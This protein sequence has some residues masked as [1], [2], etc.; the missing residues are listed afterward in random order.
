M[1]HCSFAPNTSNSSVN[2]M[3][4][5]FSTTLALLVQPSNFSF[6]LLE[7]ERTI[8]FNSFALKRVS[9]Y[10]AAGFSGLRL[11]RP[12]ASKTHSTSKIIFNLGTSVTSP[13][14][15]VTF[16]KVFHRQ[17]TMDTITKACEKSLGQLHCCDTRM[18]RSYIVF[19]DSRFHSTLHSSNQ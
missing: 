18:A 16:P 5:N 8:S 6:I 11:P 14:S 13:L 10:L 2:I 17:S 12:V 9:L 1:F 15:S 3:L 7:R 19:A 4:I